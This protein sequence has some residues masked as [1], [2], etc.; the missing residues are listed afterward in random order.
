MI[1]LVLLDAECNDIAGDG[2]AYFLRNHI[3]EASSPQE[4]VEQFISNST[5][6]YAFDSNIERDAFRERLKSRTISVV[7]LVNSKIHVF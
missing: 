3:T 7:E 6:S 2:T 5:P 4:A 1:Y